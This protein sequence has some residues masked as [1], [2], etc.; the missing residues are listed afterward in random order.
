MMK[1]SKTICLLMVA[2]AL[3]LPSC[4]YQEQKG[5][6]VSTES[7]LAAKIRRFAPTDVAADAST[8]AAG[9]REALDKI[10]QAARLMDPIYYRQVWSGNVAILQKLESDKSPAGVERLHY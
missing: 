6:T 1:S 10:I 3:A 8:L 9:D 5:P 4:T 2:L 7:P